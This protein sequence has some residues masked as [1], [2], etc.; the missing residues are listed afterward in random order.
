MRAPAKRVWGL[1][2]GPC[3][4]RRRAETST[5]KAAALQ[6]NAR[7]LGLIARSREQEKD[8]VLAPCC[9]WHTVM[10]HLHEKATF[11]V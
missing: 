8:H 3:L 7:R 2:G 11:D 9:A 5:Q 1:R 4:E 10:G 6:S